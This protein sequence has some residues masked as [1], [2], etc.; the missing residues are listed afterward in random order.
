VEDFESVRVG[1]QTPLA[2]TSED[3]RQK[4]YSARVSDQQA[5]S[6]KHSLK[7]A[8]GPNQEHAYTPHIFYKCRFE[9]GRMLGRF[10]VM[11][12]EAMSFSYQWRQYDAKYCTGPSV[13]ILPGGVVAH[14]TR[15]LLRV[16]TGK[17]VRCEVSCLL[18]ESA[19][20]GFELRV[21]LPGEA[22]PR[23][24]KSLSLDARFQRLD[25]V[26]F[27][28]RAERESTCFIDNIE[29]VPDR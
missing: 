28:A 20:E 7:F 26:G 25:W 1:G 6:G 29:V 21:W 3:A 27:I 17:W 13:T 2:T 4:Q 18:G 14:D 8:D 11:V 15:E 10:D 22:T 12:D 16:P 5:S 24:F 19:G 23:V 9:E